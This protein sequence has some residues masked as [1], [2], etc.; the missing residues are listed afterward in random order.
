VALIRAF[1]RSHRHRAEIR[2]GL[3][4]WTCVLESKSPSRR[5]VLTSTDNNNIL[6]AW[7]SSVMARHAT[8]TGR[9]PSSTH[10]LSCPP[11]ASMSAVKLTNVMVDHDSSA[12]VW[13]LF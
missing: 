7:D 4:L 6:S 5:L 11:F 3:T 8:R 10:W 1:L 12:A 9:G 13:R 2:P